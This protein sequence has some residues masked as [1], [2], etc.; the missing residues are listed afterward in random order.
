MCIY[1]VL[2]KAP[3][4]I[5]LLDDWVFDREWWMLIDRQKAFEMDCHDDGSR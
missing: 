2:Q 4:V 3:M 5:V 1:G